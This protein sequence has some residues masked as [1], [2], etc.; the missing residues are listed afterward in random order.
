VRLD[1]QILTP[2]GFTSGSVHFDHV[3]RDVTPGPAP[4]RF[5]LPGFIDTHVH[6][7]NGGDTMDGPDGV[8]CL[9]RFH[10]RHGTTSLLPTTMTAPWTDVLQALRGIADVRARGV[11]GG[12]DVLGAHLEGPFISPRRLGAQ[13]PHA[14]PPTPKRITEVLALN[15]VRV[16]TIAPEID[17][18]LDAAASFAR[19]NVRVSVGHTAGTYEDTR[20]LQD[21]VHAVGGTLGGTHLFNAMGSLQGRDPGPLGAILGCAHSFAEVILDLQHV[22]P[23]AFLAAT[24]ALRDRLTLVT[25]AIRATGLPEGESELGGQRV[26]V[27][28]G[29]ATLADGTLAGSVLTL[30]AA[31]RNAVHAGVPLAQAASLLTANPARYLGLTDRGRVE[32][33]LRADLVVLDANLNVA[34]VWLKGE[35][36]S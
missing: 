16:V 25:D 35:R 13:P 9:A 27:Q 8:R 12:A 4:D 5:V 7:G 32:A 2:R 6:G 15:V 26:L 1:G 23:G 17:G 22:H 20:A 21:R 18:A 28:E 11:S 34:E 31:L 30:D 10:A 33:G 14:L 29:R 36:V 24:A 19:A 3:I